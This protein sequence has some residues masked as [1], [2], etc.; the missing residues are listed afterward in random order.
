MNGLMAK[1]RKRSRQSGWQL[2]V[3]QKIQEAVRRTG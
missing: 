2:G 3:H 1:S